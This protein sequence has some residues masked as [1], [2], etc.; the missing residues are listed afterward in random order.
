MVVTVS[1][2]RRLLFDLRQHRS[3]NR[4]ETGV[5]VRFAPLPLDAAQC[6]AAAGT[7]ILFPRSI[8]GSLNHQNGSFSMIHARRIQTR[9]ALLAASI[10][11]FTLT[12][13]AHKE[14]DWIVRAGA[15]LVEPDES[16]S[17]LDTQ[18]AGKL[19]GTG[20]G[21]DTGSALGL[22]V[23]YMLSDSIGIELLAA[24]PFEH[25][26]SAQGVIGDLGSV[27]HLPPTLSVQ[28]Y[29][30]QG[31]A[32]R[33]YV[34]V[35]LNYTTFF[36]EDVSSSAKSALGASNLD[37]DDSVGLAA[38]LGVDWQLDDKWLL[39]AAVW[40]IDI[41]TDATLDTTAVGRV[42]VDVDIDPWVYMIGLGYKF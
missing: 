16:S 20:V 36:S 19:A 40:R 31:S 2:R 34:G 39:N 9:H 35:G 15:A 17:A 27:Q 12:A 37:L 3:V 33:P 13:Q 26:L 28:Y 10:A 42:K 1:K 6:R 5:T 11:L 14:G 30:M 41:D 29:F 18:A 23:A 32:I 21:V 4:A 22:T 7:R 25:D 38:Q 24:T 8:R